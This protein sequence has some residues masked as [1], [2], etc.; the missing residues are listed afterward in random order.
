MRFV[1][2]RVFTNRITGLLS[3]DE[4]HALQLVLWFRPEQGPIIRGGGGIRKIRWK[5]GRSGKRAGIRIIYFWDD[6][7]D[8]IYMLF[9]YPK[10]AQDDLT[11]EQ[12]KILRRLVEEELK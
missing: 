1:E 10:S 12:L 7:E 5:S 2:T 3:D 4:Y 8:T 11:P 6:P 9:A